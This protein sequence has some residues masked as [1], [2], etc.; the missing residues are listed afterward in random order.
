M[1]LFLN[2]DAGKLKFSASEE[3]IAGLP[4]YVEAYDGA[5]PSGVSAAAET[6][7]RLGRILGDQSLI[8]KG[9]LLL[10]S[11][12]GMLEKFPTGHTAMLT[13]L[14]LAHSPGREN[15]RSGNDD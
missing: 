6:Y 8:R 5:L 10:G 7:L 15:G 4:L 3:N 1:D 12:S 11:Q 14:N 9:E 13:A 2:P